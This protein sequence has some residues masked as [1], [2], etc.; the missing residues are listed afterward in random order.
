MIGNTPQERVNRPKD[1]LGEIALERYKDF[2]LFIVFGPMFFGYL[3]LHYTLHISHPFIGIAGFFGAIGTIFLGPICLLSIKTQIT[4]WHI[5]KIIIT[6]TGLYLENTQGK[7]TYALPFSRVK[8][9]CYMNND[10]D[11]ITLTSE[12][13][14]FV[15]SI[16]FELINGK[17]FTIPIEYIVEADRQ[18]TY[19][20]LASV[21]KRN[22]QTSVPTV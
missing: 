2:D 8:N 18:K 19:D 5:V 6:S 10:T 13:D 7:I 16:I 21:R 15:V 20:L 3:F 12:P 11:D 14:F 4:F 1:I 9:L 17:R 22:W